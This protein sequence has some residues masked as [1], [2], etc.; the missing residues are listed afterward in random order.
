MMM[1]AVVMPVHK[2]RSAVFAMPMPSAAVT[3]DVAMAMSSILPPM[4]D[5]HDGTIV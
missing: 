3:T 5:L 4:A 1:V 2:D